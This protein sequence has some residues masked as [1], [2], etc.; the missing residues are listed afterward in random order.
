MK[1][2]RDRFLETFNSIDFHQIKDHPNILIAARFW[3]EER[4]N[5]AKVCYKFMRRIDDL[6][7]DY[8]A[9]NKTIPPGERNQ[10]TLKVNSWLSPSVIPDSLQ[11]IK[12]ELN[13][14]IETFII[15]YGLFED[16]ARSMIYDINN[17]G[18]PDISSFLE[19]AKGASV[20]PASVFVH[21]CSI[22]TLNGRYHAPS[23]DVREAATPCALFSYLVHIIRDFRKDQINNLN[24]FAGDLVRKHGLTRNQLY[25]F[26]TGTPVNRNFRELIME[27]IKLAE[28]YRQRTFRTIERIGPLVEDRYRLSLVIIFNLYQMVFEK[29]DPEDGSFTTD[30]LN[31]TPEETREKVLETIMRFR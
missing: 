12:E 24:Y 11:S 2:Q 6:I 13:K 17:D 16:F 14:T 20:A 30:E 31:P 22:I 15:P 10:F 3:E 5:A 21:L 23:F 1:T 28:A 27:Y 26:A 18:F 4:Y 7:D 9:S 29:I 19:Y 25:E 8:K